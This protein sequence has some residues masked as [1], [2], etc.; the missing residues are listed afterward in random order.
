MYLYSKLSPPSLSLSSNFLQD[1]RTHL[2]Q[3]SR[4]A[5]VPIEPEE[6]TRLLD[7]C[8]DIPGI[9]MA[10]VPGAGGY[11]ALFIIGLDVASVDRVEMDVWA[12]W[13]MKME[14]EEVAVDRD[15]DKGGK[16]G[17]RRSHVVS[18]GPLLA[19]AEAGSR[20]LEQVFDQ[21]IIYY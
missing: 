12:C 17:S 21:R 11:D 18:I 20:G 1:V 10:G 8:M 13:E 14:E 5:H 19:E 9:I 4:L 16:L 2:R 15:D 7:A 6:Q 3:M